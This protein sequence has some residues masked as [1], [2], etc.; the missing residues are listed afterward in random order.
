MPSPG[1]PGAHTDSQPASQ[2]DSQPASHRDRQTD[3]QTDTPPHT[4]PPQDRAPLGDGPRQGRR[5]KFNP[6]FSGRGETEIARH[7]NGNCEEPEIAGTLT[8]I[9][10]H[11]NGHCEADGKLMLQPIITGTLIVEPNKLI[12]CLLPS[13]GRVN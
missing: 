5:L 10:R 12:C 7:P 4:P 2:T 8:E 9:V 11:P 3:R 1:A 13:G 6:R